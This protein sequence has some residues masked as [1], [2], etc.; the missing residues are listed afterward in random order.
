MERSPGIRSVG[1]GV[2]AGGVGPA[3]KQA[4]LPLHFPFASV[5]RLFIPHETIVPGV[6]NFHL[7]LI[8]FF[9]EKTGR[10]SDSVWRAP[11]GSELYKLDFNVPILKDSVN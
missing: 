10:N 1:E 7:Q 11:D 8:A 2:A 4:A 6:G 3:A 9:L 5:F